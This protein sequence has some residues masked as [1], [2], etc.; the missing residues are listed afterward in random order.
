M[1]GIMRSRLNHINEGTLTDY[2]TIEVRIIA[3]LYLGYR[4]YS[5]LNVVAKAPKTSV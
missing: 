1:E 5:H 2:Q 3:S 4:L